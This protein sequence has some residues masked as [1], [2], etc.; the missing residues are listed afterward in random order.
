MIL[1]IAEG[2]D[3]MTF[4]GPFNPNYY[5]ILNW[6]PQMSGQREAQFWTTVL[7]HQLSNLAGRFFLQ[8]MFQLPIKNVFQRKEKIWTNNLFFCPLIPSRWKYPN[9]FSQTR[10]FYETVP[11]RLLWFDQYST[12]FSVFHCSYSTWHKPLNNLP[13]ISWVLRKE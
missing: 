2:L 12:C 3:K 4:K 9:I 13:A 7:T 11:S 10:N 6:K 5:M 8:N 1:V